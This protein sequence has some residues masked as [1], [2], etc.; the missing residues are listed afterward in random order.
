MRRV[1]MSPAVAALAPA[2][3]PMLYGRPLLQL[4]VSVDVCVSAAVNA[5]LVPKS[6]SVGATVCTSQL[7]VIVSLTLNVAV[8]VAACPDSGTSIAANDSK[9]MERVLVNMAASLARPITS[10]TRVSRG[11]D[12]QAEIGRAHV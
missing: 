10:A 1:L 7:L 4:M 11:P 5:P 9:A 6:I 2:F 8:S 3:R 12:L